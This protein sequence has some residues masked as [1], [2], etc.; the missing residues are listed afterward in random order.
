[1]KADLNLALIKR[2]KLSEKPAGLNDSG[3]L[4][5]E[6]NVDN[7][8]YILWDSNRD[9][10]PGFGIRVARKKTYIIRRKVN[11]VS[12]MPT[13]GNV[14]D[15]L[16]LGAARKKAAELALKIVETGRNPNKDAREVSAADVTVGGALL[17]YRQHLE[18]RVKK[19]A[20]AETLRAADRH[21]RRFKE[22]GW[23]EKKVKDLPTSEIVSRF[24]AGAAHPTANE[25][26]FRFAT[27]AV[28]WVLGVEL[29]NASH[30]GRAPTLTANPFSILTLHG[31]Y[32][33]RSQLERE[34]EEKG[35][36]NPLTPSET[37]GRFLEV[38]WSKQRENDNQTGVHFLV[39]MLL[40]GFRKS[41]HA[42]CKWGELLTLDELKTTSHV[43]L[44]EAGEYGPHVFLHNTKNGRNHRLPLGRFAAELM[45]RR[46]VAAAEEAV[47]RGFS[48]KSR[49]FVF[50]ARSRFSK[51]GHYSDATALLASLRTEAEISKLTPHD[52][53]RSFG[54]VTTSLDVPE[55]IKKRFLNHAEASVTDTYTRPEWAL[56]K[57]WMERIE[58]AILSRAPNVYNAL[59][60]VDWPL[61]PAPEPHACKPSK[62]RS[63]R[64]PKAGG[65]GVDSDELG[66]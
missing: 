12:R 24:Q 64:P 5:F 2:L 11:G 35:K 19:R 27:T 61:L 50:P 33:T 1:M 7:K 34:R 38:A 57:E 58:Q 30:A 62:P 21:I 52:L 3:A 16:D 23:A 29:I 48:A 13:V 31:L 54:A 9:A 28:K 32:R 8:P 59:K 47:R 25:Q 49:V 51:M 43:L 60:P 20:A 22:C 4:I 45:R 44:S 41:E 56:L 10:P 36:R 63:G 53:R 65:A 15:F 18:T 6:A 39:L 66:L 42:K 40:L 17:A 14:A 46:Q 37:L 55:S 26:A